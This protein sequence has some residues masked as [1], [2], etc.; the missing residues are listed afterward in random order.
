MRLPYRL[1]LILSTAC[2]AAAAA[3]AAA[4]RDEWL[5]EVFL[6]RADCEPRF[7]LHYELPKRASVDRVLEKRGYA[8]SKNEQWITTYTAPAGA[9]FAG[10]RV[11][12]LAVPNAEMSVYSITVPGTPASLAGAIAARTGRRIDILHGEPAPRSGRPYVVATGPNES[13][14]VCFSFEE[15]KP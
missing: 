11:L 2:A 7:P 8:F 9:S 15:G 3:P 13:A 12:R 10:Q 4:P 14:F 6:A 5:S 1:V